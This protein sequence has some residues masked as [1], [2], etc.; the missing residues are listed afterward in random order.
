[1]EVL[2]GIVVFIMAAKG[3][4]IIAPPIILNLIWHSRLKSGKSPLFGPLGAVCAAYTVG[5]ISKIHEWLTMV[6]QFFG[7]VE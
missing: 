1:M 4:F 6:G 2:G 7:W 3:L 5:S